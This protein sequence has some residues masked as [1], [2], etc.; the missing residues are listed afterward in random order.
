MVGWLV[1][2]TDAISPKAINESGSAVESVQIGLIK[3]ATEKQMAEI[4]RRFCW[5][6]VSHLNRS[7]VSLAEKTYIFPS[8]GYTNDHQ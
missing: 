2:P 5:Q 6:S 1:G 4:F 7:D 8:L 3:V